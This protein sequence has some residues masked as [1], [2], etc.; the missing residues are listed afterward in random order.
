MG[1]LFVR[2]RFADLNQDT[3][4]GPEGKVFAQ[5]VRQARAAGL[6]LALIHEKDDL[7]RGCDFSTFFETTP[8]D[9]LND[10]I[11][12]T[13]A[14][15][16]VGGTAH[17]AVSR[18]LLAKTLGAT[19]DKRH[20]KLVVRRASTRLKLSRS[21]LN[22]FLRSSLSGRVRSR[23]STTSSSCSRA[24]SAAPPRQLHLST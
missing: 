12:S 17:R 24:D 2:P 8:T 3:Y 1:S 11:Y 20:A 15:T 9:L 14:T 13:L 23:G 6:R 7:L 22:E 10:G 18:A 16:F 21:K 19:I 5:E 4:L